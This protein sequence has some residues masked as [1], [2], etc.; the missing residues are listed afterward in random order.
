MKT[1]GRKCHKLRLT[2][3]RLSPALIA[4]VISQTVPGNT[5]YRAELHLWAGGE[6]ESRP[7]NPSAR[8]AAR[9]PGDHEV[10]SA[11]RGFRLVLPTGGLA[12]L[13]GRETP[14][15]SVRQ[16]CLVPPCPV[17]T[18]LRTAT[19]AKLGLTQ[20]A[21]DLI[22]SFQGATGISEP[23]PNE[24]M[25]FGSANQTKDVLIQTESLESSFSACFG[26][27]SQTN[28]AGMPSLYLADFYS[29]QPPPEACSWVGKTG[30]EDPAQTNGRTKPPC[31]GACASGPPAQV[32]GTAAGNTQ[33]GCSGELSF[34]RRL[35]E[36]HLHQSAHRRQGGDPG[37]YES[38]TI[39]SW[40][41][42]YLRIFTFALNHSDTGETKQAA[43]IT[44]AVP[45][46]FRYTEVHWNKLNI[47]ETSLI[48]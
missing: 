32:T 20:H 22:A 28:S 44:N 40:P 21:Q 8:P 30:R 24:F 9:L 38:G 31:R 34:T 36:R 16:T 3:P 18:L 7:R 43:E 6:A 41:S 39:Y 29:F 27:E 46:E 37:L 45:M 17:S 19:A 15:N 10:R 2:R 5:F 33:V 12:S 47:E 25:D 26:R 35:T 1:R 23:V 4:D 14:L 11:G 42:E 48:Q 13:S